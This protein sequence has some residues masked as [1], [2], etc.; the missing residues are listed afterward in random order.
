MT[1]P[2]SSRLHLPLESGAEYVQCQQ[3]PQREK[4]NGESVVDAAPDNSQILDTHLLP[5]AQVSLPSNREDSGEAFQFFEED[6]VV[7]PQ[8]P[9]SS[10]LSDL[11][12]M[13]TKSEGGRPVL[14]TFSPLEQGIVEDEPEDE[15]VETELPE[16]Q[17]E[18]INT[19]SHIC[20]RGL[21]NR[22]FLCYQNSVIQML[23]ASDN[24]R[25]K[26]LDHLD[27]MD[28]GLQSINSNR[29][30]HRFDAP[31]CCADEKCFICALG[32]VVVNHRFCGYESG[33]IG[34]NAAPL[35]GWVRDFRTFSASI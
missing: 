11:S 33:S 4:E 26:F 5:T 14:F 7:V 32:W 16:I 18:I 35:N 21:D 19:R 3:T 13:W 31:S 8:S 12:D 23:C 28:G 29:G 2:E 27:A 25:A 10:D 1:P 22:R 20:I 15:P 34:S 24:L 6:S 17:Q 30:T 9:Q